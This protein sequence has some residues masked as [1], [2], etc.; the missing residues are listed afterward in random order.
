MV[1]FIVIFALFAWGILH[2]LGKVLRKEKK[3]KKKKVKK[4]N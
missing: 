2:F 1:Y 3:D 4:G